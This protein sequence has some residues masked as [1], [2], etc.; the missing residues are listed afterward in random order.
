MIF[1]T[2][3]SLYKAKQSKQTSYKMFCF[4]QEQSEQIKVNGSFQA[5]KQLTAKHLVSQDQLFT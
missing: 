2:V 1:Q 5:R 3:Y 4:K